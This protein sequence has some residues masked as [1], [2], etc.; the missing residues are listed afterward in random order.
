VDKRTAVI[1]FKVLE[2]IWHV[3]SRSLSTSGLAAL[4]APEIGLRSTAVPE[5]NA[6]GSI[7]H[8]TLK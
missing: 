8:P 7:D 3:A 1:A 2:P 5:I 4:N 6:F